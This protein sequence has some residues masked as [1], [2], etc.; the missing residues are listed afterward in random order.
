MN[1]AKDEKEH[2]CPRPYNHGSLSFFPNPY[3]DRQ[4][5]GG[6]RKG[7][8]CVRERPCRHICRRKWFPGI[9]MH[10]ERIIR[11][12]GGIA[13][14]NIQHDPDNQRQHYIVQNRLIVFVPDESQNAYSGYDDF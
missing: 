4:E 6:D 5:K 8:E 12:H 2:N 14:D 3:A 1:I 7:S 10:L 11:Y 9:K 13:A